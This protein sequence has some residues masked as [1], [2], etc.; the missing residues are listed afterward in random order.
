MVSGIKGAIPAD[1]Q[2]KTLRRK[3]AEV[4]VKHNM[5][6]RQIAINEILNLFELERKKTLEEVGEQIRNL[7]V[8]RVNMEDYYLMLEGTK[9]LLKPRT[10]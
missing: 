2:P 5:P 10:L 4:L 9:L 3:I 6:T 1:P 8:Q 7:N